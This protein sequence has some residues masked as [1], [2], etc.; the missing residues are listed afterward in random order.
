MLIIEDHTG[1]TVR[2]QSS[3]TGWDLTDN[4]GRPVTSGVYRAYALLRNGLRRAATGAV[5][6][7]VLRNK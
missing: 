7:I 6:V 5:E 3:L 4:E 1:S 2:S